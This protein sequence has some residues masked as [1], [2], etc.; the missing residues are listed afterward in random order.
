M[1]EEPTDLSR[2]LATGPAQEWGRLPVHG[3][4]RFAEHY[5]HHQLTVRTSLIWSVKLGP[6]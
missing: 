5:H 3:R 2:P 6:S 4:G 1:S